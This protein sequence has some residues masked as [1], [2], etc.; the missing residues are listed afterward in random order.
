MISRLT[1]L[2]ARG[3]RNPDRIPSYLLGT[4]LPN[5]KWSSDWK[6]ENGIVRWDSLQWG[7]DAPPKTCAEQYYTRQLL[8]EYL[9][10]WTVRT[11][12]DLGCGF[13]RMTPWIDTFATTTYGVDPNP[14]MIELA[15]AYYPEIEFRTASAQQLPFADDQF[16]VV[17]T[18]GVLAHIP[19]ENIERATA[20]IQRVL[21]PGGRVLLLEFRFGPDT[22][23]PMAWGRSRAEYT[24][25]FDTLELVTSGTVKTPRKHRETLPH[26]RELMVFRNPTDSEAR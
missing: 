2:V 15:E 10:R 23:G 1:D 20:E 19:P 16:D 14:E 22:D 17:F 4:A 6:S 5:S 21:A 25:L 11:A 12:L 18:R 24:A 8:R 9:G 26:A 7:I 3:L 13:G